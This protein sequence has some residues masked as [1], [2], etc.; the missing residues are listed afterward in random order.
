MSAKMGLDYD[1]C[2]DQAQKFCV[3]V[4][5]P[6]QDVSPDYF[7]KFYE[8]CFHIAD[9]HGWNIDTV[10][11]WQLRPLGGRLIKTRTYGWYLRWDDE[12][13]HTM[14]VLRWM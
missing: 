14:F 6:G 8:H 2:Y 1:T 12:K 3:T 10:A 13:E 7:R 9:A 11:N 5:L 4:A